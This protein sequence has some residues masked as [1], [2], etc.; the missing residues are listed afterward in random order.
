LEDYASQACGSKVPAV[1]SY[2]SSYC[3]DTDISLYC[4]VS[5]CLS[6]HGASTNL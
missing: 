2:G 4:R 3:A 6:L 5:A 1:I